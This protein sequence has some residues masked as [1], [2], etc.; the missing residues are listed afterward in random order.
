MKHCTAEQV[1]FT[2]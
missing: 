1:N 2:R